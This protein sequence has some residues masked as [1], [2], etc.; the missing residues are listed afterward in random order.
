[1][2]VLGADTWA[3]CADPAVVQVSTRELHLLRLPDDVL[4]RWGDLPARLRQLPDI[5]GHILELRLLHRAC[6]QVLA[7][8]DCQFANACV[9]LLLCAAKE[10]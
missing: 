7:E 1:M 8:H 5:A 9:P 3:S 10:L 6:L 2:G 4:L